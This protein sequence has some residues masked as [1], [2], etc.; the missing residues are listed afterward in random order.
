[1]SGLC[2]LS[3]SDRSCPSPRVCRCSPSK[4]RSPQ[5]SASVP[6]SLPA[7]APGGRSSS[8]EEWAGGRPSEVGLR[9]C[10]EC[11]PK[12]LLGFV[13][14]QTKSGNTQLGNPSKNVSAVVFCVSEQA[15]AARPV[16]E[17]GH[18]KPTLLCRLVQYSCDCDLCVGRSGRSGV[19]SAR[20]SRH[21]RPRRTPT[22]GFA[23][24]APRD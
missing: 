7:P 8:W 10:V 13:S 22:G 1:M 5:L 15:E 3:S 24:A 17:S 18:C 16:R 4:A 20:A 11:A 2:P 12:R 21:S 23:Q 9:E 6:A 19:W 14:G